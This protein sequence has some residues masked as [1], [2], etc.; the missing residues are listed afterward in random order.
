MRKIVIIGG[1]IS[2]L[3]CLHFLRKRLGSGINVSLFE[4]DAKVGGHVRSICEDGFLF[5]TGPNGFLANQPSTFEL[6]NDIGLTD[7]LLEANA[8]AHRRYVNFNGR[9]HPVPAN[10]GTFLTTS[11]LNLKDKFSLIRGMLKK[12]ISK[13]RSVYD[14]A[15]RRFGLGAAQRL[16]DPFVSGV[17][18]GDIQRL[19]MASSFPK[20]FRAGTKMH[21][22]KQGM[23]QIIG[24]LYERYKN[25]ITLNH[26]IDD[27]KNIEA[28]TIVLST[29][30]LIAAELLGMDALRQ[31]S[32]AP[33]VVVG[34]GYKK[35]RFKTIPDGFG[36]LIPSVEKNPVLGIVLE[37]N[38]F[39][40][41][42]PVDCMMLRVMMGGRHQPWVAHK[43]RDELIVL[44]QE[45]I[46]RT[47]GLHGMPEKVFI[48]ILPNAI[49][50][51]ELNYP[52]VC[53]DIKRFLTGHPNMRLLGNYLGGISFNDC[54]NNAKFIAHSITL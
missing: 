38:I 30:A 51:Y 39:A 53:A 41:R 29:P 35:T 4:R 48:Q 2:G 49:P 46:D 25:F 52:S 31:I 15:C 42:A 20:P 24:R 21:S 5:E 23:G 7:Q 54:V 1:G 47:Y 44:A 37:N 32:Y 18:A 40:S 26:N 50:Q 33:V 45:E 22:F 14:Y 36:Y 27:L 3:A 28:D 34:L 6:I 13:D 19:H 10:V 17:F 16:F 43:T 9:L 11:L 12:D 8:N